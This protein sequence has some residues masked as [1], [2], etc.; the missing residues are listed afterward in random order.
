MD[1][2]LQES[3]QVLLASCRFGFL[4][5]SATVPDRRIMADVPHGAVLIGHLRGDPVDPGLLLLPSDDDGFARVD[6]DEGAG[7]YLLPWGR[8]GR[9]P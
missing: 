3:V 9:R 4:G 2:L 7:P 6:P 5:A 1:D 8:G